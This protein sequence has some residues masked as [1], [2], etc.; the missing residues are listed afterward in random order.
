MVDS[1]KVLVEIEEQLAELESTDVM[2]KILFIKGR[3]EST[4]INEWAL[5]VLV[6]HVFTLCKIMPNLS[7]LKDFAYIKAEAVAEEYKSAVRDKFIELKNS[8]EK[9]TDSL[10]RSLAEKECDKLK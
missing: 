6:D 3:L 2:E 7:D 8:G 4:P 9:M 5:N 10:A 1:N